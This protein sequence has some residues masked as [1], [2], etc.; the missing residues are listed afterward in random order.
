MGG[1]PI[2]GSTASTTMTAT[3]GI[4]PPLN[5]ERVILMFLLT[6]E[7]A[8]W[9]DAQYYKHHDVNNKHLSSST[10]EIATKSLS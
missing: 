3:N 1:T 8:L 10:E 9:P 5:R 2:I 4:K 7:Y 6:T